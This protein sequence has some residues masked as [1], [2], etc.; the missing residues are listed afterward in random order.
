MNQPVTL[1]IRDS[2][3]PP[4]TAELTL[5]PLSL[6]QRLGR[7]LT[8][9]GVCWA[10]AVPCVLVP[11]LHF[12]LVPGLV[13]LGPL[14]GALAFRAT[15][16]VTSERVKCPKCEQDTPIEPGTTGWPVGLRCAHCSTTFRATA[17]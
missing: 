1:Q 17:S 3:R 7:A 5:E 13:L 6:R 4:T 15:V 16:V 2:A 9:V 10:V 12:V 11:L 8:R 14:L